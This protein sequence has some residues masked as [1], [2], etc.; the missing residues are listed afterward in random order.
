VENPFESL[1]DL[2]FQKEIRDISTD[3][4]IYFQVIFN[5]NLLKTLLK[6]SI[7]R[8]LK[9]D[10]TAYLSNIHLFS[11]SGCIKKYN[12]AIDVLLEYFPVRIDYY[13]KRKVRFLFKE[14]RI[15]THFMIF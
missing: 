8:V 11:P 2:F 10:R 1:F 15:I 12:S 9:F 7:E 14:Y 4:N 13:Q 5:D 6:G 3:S